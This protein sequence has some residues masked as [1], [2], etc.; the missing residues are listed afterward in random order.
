MERALLPSV[1]ARTH[2]RTRHCRSHRAAWT[3]RM[4]VNPLSDATLIGRIGFGDAVLEYHD[5]GISSCPCPLPRATARGGRFPRRDLHV[6]DG[7][8]SVGEHQAGR[9]RGR[10]K[11]RMEVAP[12]RPHPGDEAVIRDGQT[13]RFAPNEYRGADRAGGG[14][15]R[16][17]AVAAGPDAAGDAGIDFAVCRVIND[18]VVRQGDLPGR[19]A[20]APR[21]GEG[22]WRKQGS[23]RPSIPMAAADGSERV[24]VHA[25][26]NFL[27]E[28]MGSVGVSSDA[29]ARSIDYQ[30]SI[31]TQIGSRGVESVTLKKMRQICPN[32]KSGALI[33]PSQ[34]AT[35][36]R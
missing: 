14:I 8:R 13:V 3:S 22:Q 29:S 18:V 21:L 36:R 7:T 27:S 31:I 28:A 26:K 23:C 33:Y 25:W 20:L 19:S 5:A 2:C 10:V 35:V 30:L 1:V 9:L 4:R 11:R 15:D 17:D 32:R 34:M 12:S 24:T 16:R 6:F